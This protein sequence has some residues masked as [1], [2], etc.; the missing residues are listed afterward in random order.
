MEVVDHL[1]AP[2]PEAA[3][4]AAMRADMA[5]P[6]DPA[7]AP[8]FGFALH[9]VAPDRTLW[10][11]RVHHIA[12]DAYG[13]SLLSRRTAEVYT[14][15][16]RGESPPLAVRPA[17]R[18][19]R[20]GGRLP[21]RRAVRRRPRLLAGP[22]RGPRRPRAAGR[23]LLPAAPDFL[24]A[25]AALTPEAT[26]GV[27]ALARAAKATWA[28]AVTAAF[29]A[30]LHR[31]TG[32]RDV[33]LSLPA[34]ARL[35]SASLSV[36]AMVVNVLPLR[37]AVRPGLP[38]AELVAEVAAGVRDLRRHQ[39]Y[40]AE[41]IRRD[42]GLVGRDRGPLGPMV[43]VKAFD[44]ALDFAGAPGTVH[45]VAAGP[46]DDLTLAVRHDTAAGRIAFE[47]DANPRAYDAEGLDARCAEFVRFL[48]EAATAGPDTPWAAPTSSTTPSWRRSPRR[49]PR[50]PARW[51]PAP[52]SRPSP[53]RRGSTRGRRARRGRRGA[54]VRGTRRPGR[55]AGPTA[56][57]ARRRPRAVRRHRPA[58]RRRPR[59]RPARRAQSRRRL[60]AARP[61]IPRR[62]PGV[63]GRGRAPGVRPHHPGGR[64]RRPRR[65]RH[66]DPR[67]GLPDA[68]SALADLAASPPSRL[69]PRTATTRRTSS[70]PRAPPAAPRAW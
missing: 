48:T 25:E 14:A 5:T 4:L 10:Y 67:P 9:R 43:N 19:R 22:A 26:A 37:V 24:R 17:V 44:N 41:D 53:H 33:L 52:S 69:R 61:R 27:F 62:A 32:D 38:L 40:R 65:A 2:D 56:R 6:A 47:L 8:L 18:R 70:T 49:P 66:R 36:P 45:N 7:T 35:G 23:R 15:L 30:F 20:R 51:R 13:F 59:R 50:P 3:A 46:V 34:M 1:G 55:P 28:D 31:S 64:G 39:R 60:S 57:R 21:R 11:Q 58:A 16:A 54:H 63:H 12:L 29:A 42:L 68:L